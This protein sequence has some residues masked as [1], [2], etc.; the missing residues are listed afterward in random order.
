[1]KSIRGSSIT[2]DRFTSRSLRLKTEE[3]HLLLPRLGLLLGI[4]LLLALA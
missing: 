1:M 3:L 2:D 4:Q